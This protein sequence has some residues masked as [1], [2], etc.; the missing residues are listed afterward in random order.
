MTNPTIRRFTSDF[1][2]PICGGHQNLPRGQ[3]IRCSGYLSSDGEYAHCGRSEPAGSLPRGN[4]GTYP[5]RLRGNCGC[6][7]PHTKPEGPA[8]ASSEP[9]AIYDYIDEDG[10]HWEKGRFQHQDGGKSF[11]WRAKGQTEWKGR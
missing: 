1:P 4:G 7:S 2:C 3:G 9:V 6:G 5:H 8:K 10:S 11:S